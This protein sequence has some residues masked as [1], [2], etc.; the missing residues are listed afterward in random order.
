MKQKHIE[1]RFSIIKYNK[2]Y[3]YLK[4]N[5]LAVINVLRISSISNKSV[6]SFLIDIIDCLL[7]VL[8]TS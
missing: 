2:S 7:S 4:A 3:T 5:A 1:K 8:E 6:T